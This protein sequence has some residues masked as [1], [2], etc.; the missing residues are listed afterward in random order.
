M[1]NHIVVGGTFDTLHSGHAHFLSRAFES[2]KT[3]TIGLT[4]EAYI[5]RFK[6]DLGVSPFSI[7]YR[8][9]IAWLRKHGY[10]DRARIV[11]LDNK[12]GP[13]LLPDG[14]DAIA[15]TSQNSNTAL[16]I[17]IIRTERGLPPLAVVEI[18]LVAAE[19]RKPISST[20]IRNR[21]INTRGALLLPD[22]LRPELQKPLGPIIANSACKAHI[23]AHKDAI[24]ITVGDV[25]TETVFYCGVQPSLVVVDLHVE[26]KPYRSLSAYKLPKKYEILHLQ[27][28]P[29]FIS[30]MA[31]R[32][33]SVWKSGIRLRKRVAMI[34]E[35]EEDLLVLPIVV[36]APIGSVVYY[37]SPPISGTEGL[38]EV[39]VTE[40]IK[41]KVKALMSQ[42]TRISAIS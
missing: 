42:F 9:L 21:Q 16:E 20:R 31:I 34:V 27:S 40:E 7:R 29:G 39:V 35:G 18:D 22:S 2:A 12:W 41:Q 37:G 15:V 19:D 24:C 5:R 28:G 30:K 3:V 13:V 25:T 17:N 36:A 10:S 6:K 33:I 23:T 38:V 32:A 14:F 1:Y 26:R 11:S 4:S 8:A